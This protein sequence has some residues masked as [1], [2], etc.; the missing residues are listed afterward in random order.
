MA[1]LKTE[2]LSKRFG[3][4]LAVDGVS[5]DVQAGEIKSLIGPNG[6]GKTTLF[7]LVT[8]L[9]APDRGT[10]RFKDRLVTGW[11]PHRI[12]GTGVSRTFQNPS[13]FGRMNV[14][15]NVMVGG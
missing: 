15:E 12:A 8:G 4:L 11:K 5:F 2:G 14:L 1:L 9:L 6:A 3:G 7:N 10:V 13:L